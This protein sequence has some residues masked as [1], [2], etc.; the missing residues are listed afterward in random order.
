M[1][2][3][4]ESERGRPVPQTDQPPEGVKIIK[5]FES[6]AFAAHCFATYDQKQKKNKENRLFAF[7]VIVCIALIFGMRS[8]ADEYPASV[9]INGAVCKSLY[10]NDTTGN[11]LVFREVWCIDALTG[12]PDLESGIFA[13]VAYAWLKRSDAQVTLNFGE[14]M[15]GRNIR[16]QL[17]QLNS[18]KV[19]GVVVSAFCQDGVVVPHSATYEVAVPQ[20]SQTST[21][22]VFTKPKQRTRKKMRLF[23]AIIQAPEGAG[24]SLCLQIDGDG[25]TRLGKVSIT[26]DPVTYTPVPADTGNNNGGEDQELTAQEECEA[27]GNFWNGQDCKEP[28]DNG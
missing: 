22:W 10:V 20:T 16:V 28:G 15:A 13:G 8:Y 14:S 18:K 2:Y 4:I 17:A 24:N 12:G 26:D 25:S 1:I 5:E 19:R 9:D 11:H 3:I 21:N 7:V 23:E 6:M 27:E